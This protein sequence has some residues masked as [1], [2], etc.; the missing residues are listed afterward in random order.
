MNIFLVED[1]YWALAELVELFRVYEPE[2]RIYSFSNGE[3][4]LE[5][6]GEILP[7]LVLTDI[8]MPGMDGLE[9]VKELN[10]LDPS[11]KKMIISVHDQF[12]YARMGMK[13]GV[14]DFLVKPVSKEALYKA[15]DQA[16]RQLLEERKKTEEWFHVSLTRMLLTP[17]LPSDPR[18]L[19]FHEEACLLILV[20]GEADEGK[21]QLTN[22]MQ[23]T[24]RLMTL[25]CV[26][27]KE[28]FVKVDLDGRHKVFLS[29]AAASLRQEIVKT[30]LTEW[31]APQHHGP[32]ALHIGFVRKPAGQS[33]F[34]V[35]ERLKKHLE[36]HKLFEFPTIVSMNE[37]PA[38]ADL[39]GVWDRIR[40]LESH[41]RKGEL[42]KG[43]DVLMRLLNELRR[44]RLTKRQLDLLMN[45]MF[46]SLKFNLYRS[47]TGHLPVPD[48]HDDS[49]LFQH[50]YYY[51]KL[52]SP[53]HD[54]LVELYGA[55][56]RKEASPKELIPILLH[57]IH[58]EYRNH[59]SLQ[60]FAQQHHVSLG[61]LSRMF[62]EQTGFTFSDYVTELRIRKAK[63]LLCGGACGLQEVSRLVG[64]EDPKYFS[65]QFKKLVGMTP[66]LYAKQAMSASMEPES[67]EGKNVPLNR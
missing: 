5:A 63:E 39:G 15:V 57:L 27:A 61:Y 42:S 19:G 26:P 10:L 34:E 11:I 51:D 65:A 2:H 30:R 7:D 66:H 55:E 59:M 52:L 21:S 23:T 43:K 62:K 67:S 12:E 54:K 48:L 8:N 45:D 46:Y 24:E 41:Y 17:E 16:L 40:I 37:Q 32:E 49:Q 1:E 9:L 64:Y 20:S 44:H 14:V 25:L 13:F 47:R 28:D 6:A 29:R 38:D 56:D 22:S 36:E 35:L 50:I 53:L 18:L 58:L 33:L 31:V 3:E 4:A 60:Q